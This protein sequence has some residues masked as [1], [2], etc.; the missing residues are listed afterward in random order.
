MS[1]P[2]PSPLTDRVCVGQFAGAHGVRGLVRIRSFTE[3]PMRVASYGPVEDE[4]GTRIFRLTPKSMAKGAVIAEVEGIADRDQAQLLSGTR[5]YVARDRLPPLEQ[6][7]EFYHADLIGC[8]VLD[9]A[10]RPL[11]TVHAVH[12]FGA[13][14][15]LEVRMSGAEPLLLPFTE[16]A[17]PEVDLAARRIVADP[18]DLVGDGPHDNAAEGDAA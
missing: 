16:A 18:P 15:L 4:A 13:G 2:A 8:A 3:E 14:T 10:G 9:S 12:D 17:V 7:G 6:E 11:G 5:L 1:A